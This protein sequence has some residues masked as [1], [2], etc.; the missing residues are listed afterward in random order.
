MAAEKELMLHRCAIFGTRKYF[1]GYSETLEFLKDCIRQAVADGFLTFVTR[2]QDGYEL[3]AARF[4]C[5]IKEKDP[6]I[7]LIIT[8][9]YSNY[10]R[11]WKTEWL[12]EDVCKR[13]DLVKV[14]SSHDDPDANSKTNF[15]TISKCTRIIIVKNAPGSKMQ[16]LADLDLSEK[17]VVEVSVVWEEKNNAYVRA[18]AFEYQENE[19]YLQ[20]APEPLLF[21]YNLLCDIAQID[22]SDAHT[23]PEDFPDDVLDRVFEVLSQFD[24]R[25]HEI[26]T[27][28]Y[29]ENL[30]LQRIADRFDLS[31]E[32]IRQI[33]KKA[34]TRMRRT[35]D[36]SFLKGYDLSSAIEGKK[37]E[38]EGGN[39][40]WR[41]WSPAEI[42]QL[43]REINTFPLPEVAERHSRSQDSIIRI[44]RTRK[45]LSG[46]QYYSYCGLKP[47]IAVS[48]EVYMN[49]GEKW[50]EEEE[51][52]LLEEYQ[53]GEDVTSMASRHKRTTGAIIARLS[54]LTGQD[55]DDLRVQ[56]AKRTAVVI[57]KETTSLS[58]DSISI[59][60]L[61]RRMTAEI[62]KDRAIRIRYADIL[63][64]LIA[65]GDME[66]IEDQEKLI[67]KPTK[68]GEN[69][70]IRR[71]KRQNNAGLEYVGVFLSRSA[72]EYVWENLASILTQI[73][74]SPTLTEE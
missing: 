44:I 26:M 1:E 69:H 30:S 60:E 7:H 25:V 51:K 31:R 63:Q 9:P 67:A 6:R 65:A 49:A 47:T 45:L 24:E 27:L 8:I 36:F 37:T 32:R 53:G 70:G 54:R 43:K 33:I 66:Q 62:K 20:D 19:K 17:E 55:R 52:A 72:Q 14:I 74:A 4:I 22:R 39:R 29:C 40:N 68:Q 50:T 48:S 18:D 59:S 15:W 23:L 10:N 5:E 34:I 73:Q 16:R 42:D 58:S 13:A 38:S 11:Y 28:R 35:T 3:D 56:F 64:W 46:E 61:A 71:E 21:P 12:F 57:S 41:P 2:A